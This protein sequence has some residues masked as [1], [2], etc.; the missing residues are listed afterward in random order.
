MNH[1]QEHRKDAA[2]LANAG[3]EALLDIFAPYRA[4]WGPKCG[5]RKQHGHGALARSGTNG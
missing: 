5:V 2:A 4:E 3:A 1:G